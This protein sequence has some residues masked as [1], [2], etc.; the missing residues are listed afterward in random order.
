MSSATN[1]KSARSFSSREVLPFVSS[2]AMRRTSSSGSVN[3]RIASEYH[4]RKSAHVLNVEPTIIG[5][6]SER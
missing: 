3:P 6:S 4:L 1:S 2:A 5:A